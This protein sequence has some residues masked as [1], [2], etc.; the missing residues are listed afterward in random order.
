MA[1]KTPAEIA[2]HV[3]SVGQPPVAGGH[4]A[5]GVSPQ[6]APEKC[7]TTLGRWRD[8]VNVVLGKKV[9]DESKAKLKGL[10]NSGLTAKVKA[11]A[12]LNGE[13]HFDDTFSE[14]LSQAIN[15][16]KSSFAAILIKSDDFKPS[17][18]SGKDQATALHL[19]IEKRQETTAN[20]IVQ[21]HR[22]TVDEQDKY[23]KTPLFCAV[24]TANKKLTA[25][26]LRNHAD[27]NA[28][29]S[30]HLTPL[31]TVAGIQF[32][33]EGDS[34]IDVV[35][36]LLSHGAEV[37]TKDVFGESPLHDAAWR[38]DD[39]LM[40]L[41]LQHGADA[42][43][44]NFDGQTPRDVLPKFLAPTTLN[45]L[46]L[47]FEKVTVDNSH[48]IP[49]N[50]PRC[51]NNAPNDA[52]SE[53]DSLSTSDATGDV[54]ERFF[55]TVRFFYR[56]EGFSRSWSFSMHSLLHEDIDGGTMNGLETEFV[57]LVYH[58]FYISSTQDKPTKMEIKANIWK[59][60]HVPANQMSWVTDLVW[61][62]TDDNGRSLARGDQPEARKEAWKFLERNIAQRKGVKLH[63]FTRVPH[64]GDMLKHAPEEAPGTD[65]VSSDDLVEVSESSAAS[66]TAGLYRREIWRNTTTF[67]D[68]QRFSLVV[69][70]ID[71]E[72]EQYLQRYDRI[73]ESGRY[74]I[75]TPG[76]R[77]KRELE[78]RSFLYDGLLGLHKPRTLDEWYYDMLRHK[79]L[80]IRDEDQ[81]VF[82]WFKDIVQEGL[83]LQGKEADEQD[84][85]QLRP[86][87]VASFSIVMEDSWKNLKCKRS[88]TTEQSEFG[89]DTV[90]TSRLPRLLMVHQLWL[91][92]LDSS[93]IITAFPDRYHQG[94]EDTLFET[95]RQGGI[96]S[97]TR[98]EQLIENILFECVTFLEEYRFAGL[99]IHILDI[100][101]SSIAVRSNQEAVLFKKFRDSIKEKKRSLHK[102]VDSDIALIHEIKDIR[103]ELH[104]LLRIFESQLDVVQKF[105]TIF[106]SAEDAAKTG[107]AFV[108][109]CGVQKII[110]RTKALDRHAQRTLSDLDYLVQMKQAQ[111]SLEEAETAGRLNNYIMLFTLV[112]IVFTPLSF[113]TSLFA[114]PFDYF[115]Q[116]SDGEIR[117]E[118][119]WFTERMVAG[120]FT[121]LGFVLLFGTAMYYGRWP[122]R[123]QV[124]QFFQS[125]WKKASSSPK[126]ASSSSAVHDHHDIASLIER[127][128]SRA[129]RKQRFGD[130]LD[131][132]SFV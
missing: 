57:D 26:L 68:D 59:W 50:P 51:W 34:R 61:R 8:Q 53:V 124:G 65:Q 122:S 69:P 112:T 93:T 33:P 24:R 18:K 130:S 82:K 72:T 67:A 60:I 100:F 66:E 58:K 64:A 70:Y 80:R 7:P 119:N 39:K 101:E 52:V 94:V 56:K 99:G 127:S 125:P 41:L 95:I 1:F 103:D 86:E 123:R 126:H 63:S 92:K 47:A 83:L 38:F 2:T 107:K 114:I 88:L 71:F 6:L 102:Q 19:A 49:T 12:K 21:K 109:D 84:F 87:T 116:N 117:V 15:T 46:M 120:E 35:N 16:N 81:V 113:L 132:E 32:W 27:V 11:A 4:A 40:T 3:V 17:H 129:W 10:L 25:F 111:S 23:G 14:L 29:D 89:Q 91:W 77:D 105:A 106:W 28:L 55:A 20:K 118:S 42:E 90:N 13:E 43:C 37:N 54:C 31:H 45:G 9:G 30:Q 74:E 115:P 5:R 36:E 75:E 48:S 110:D 76:F 85:K 96:E 79:D 62:L 73:E 104:L 22:G 121:T 98:P 44:R 131:E 78:H 108:N 97:Y 128:K